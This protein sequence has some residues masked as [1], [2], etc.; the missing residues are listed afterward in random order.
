MVSEKP[1]IVR[2]NIVIHEHNEIAIYVV[3]YY[4]LLME[5]EIID[6]M[7]VDKDKVYVVKEIAYKEIDDDFDEKVVLVLLV[8]K[9]VI[10]L[11][12]EDEVLVIE[13]L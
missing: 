4:V 8:L 3:P 9:E 5:N 2:I 10:L 11:V 7:N 1:G 12:L 13:N 6:I